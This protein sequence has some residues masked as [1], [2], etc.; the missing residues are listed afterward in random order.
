MT[1]QTSELTTHKPNPW[2]L[3]V[4]CGVC[5][6]HDSCGRVSGALEGLTS[7]FRGVFDLLPGQWRSRRADEKMALKKRPDLRAE[8]ERHD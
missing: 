6:H 7:G 2:R 1:I 8:A 3:L 5:P 4:G